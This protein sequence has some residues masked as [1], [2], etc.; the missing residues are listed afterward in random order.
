MMPE[1]VAQ[2]FTGSGILEE[3]EEQGLQR[4]NVPE[5]WGQEHLGGPQ[6]QVPSALQD[7]GLPRFMS[8]LQQGTPWLKPQ[9]P[10]MYED[11]AGL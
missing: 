10:H 6:S 8:E 9:R 2:E 5:A 7:P 1:S 11:M 4:Y 3:E